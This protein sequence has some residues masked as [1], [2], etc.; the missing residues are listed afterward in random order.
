MLSEARPIAVSSSPDP[1]GLLTR[2]ERL[3]NQG[4]EG[5]AVSSE[6]KCE[7]FVK[8]RARGCRILDFPEYG[9]L[10][11]VRDWDGSLWNLG[12]ECR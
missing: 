9:V 3:P 11:A 2:C 7:R 8:V 12:C 6:E 10:Y 4:L 1:D 5:A